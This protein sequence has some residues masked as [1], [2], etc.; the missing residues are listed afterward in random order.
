MNEQGQVVLEGS[1][2]HCCV[3]GGFGKLCESCS[4]PRVDC[5]CDPTM[6]RRYDETCWWCDGIGLEPEGM[7]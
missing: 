4:N 3:C 5:E 7:E 1:Q 2:E 6:Y